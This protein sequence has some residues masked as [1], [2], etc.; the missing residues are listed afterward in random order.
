MGHSEHASGTPAHSA[1]RLAGSASPYLLQHARNPVQWW[2]WG[3]EAF[4]AASQRDVP[5]FLSIGYSTCYWC[6]VMERESFESASTAALLNER[7]V[8][9]KV[10]REERP[11][12]DDIYMN[13]VQLMSGSGGWPMSV[14][15]TP[16]GARSADDPGLEPFYAGTYFPPAP[17]HGRPSFKQV[18][19]GV[20]EAWSSQRE[21]VLEQA[22]RVTAAIR[23]YL[24][25]EFDPVRVDERQIGQAIGQLL[26]MHDSEHGG[27]GGA[28]KFPQPVY[29][30]FL[31]ETLDGI[32]DP[33]A[34]SSARRA[35]RRTLDR[36][37]TGGLFD[38][39]GGGFHRY[40]VDERWVVPHFEK[41]L[42]DNAQLAS[43]YARSFAL[44]GDE[45][46]ARICRRTLD[47]ALREMRDANGGFYSAQDAE[48]DTRE[49]LNYL[50]MPDEVRSAIE[51]TLGMDC[52]ELALRLYALDGEPNFRDPHHPEEPR[53]F[54]L[55]LTDRPDA[56]GEANG[57][58]RD[59]LVERMD[60]INAALLT[61]RASRKQP[62]L[63]D[64]VI[65]AW[66]GM[67]IAGLA[68]GAMALGDHAYLEAARQAAD[69]VLGSMRD[70]RGDLVR[71]WRCGES[72][73]AGV[74]EDYAFVVQGLLALHRAVSS[75]GDADSGYFKA[76]KQ[77][78]DR[79]RVHFADEHG[80]LHDTRN[81][82]SDLVVRARSSYDGAI[83][84]AASTMLHNFIDLFL[85]SRDRGSLEAAIAQ[86]AGLSRE[87][88][89]SPVATINATRAVYRLIALDPEI[90]RALPE[91]LGDADQAATLSGDPRNLDGNDPVVVLASTD[92]VSI[93]RGTPG[94]IRLR[95][96]IAPGYH[97]N[98]HDPGLSDLVGLSVRI[99]NG[100]G[101]SAHASYPPGVPLEAA[102]A[103]DAG[104]ADRPGP[105]VHNAQVELDVEL[106][107][108]DEAWS[109]RPLLLLEYQ[110]CTDRACLMPR[111]VE[112]DVALDP[113]D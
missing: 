102:G 54:V 94:S 60:A 22:S 96:E 41:M 73:A 98:A 24:S 62:S 59:E 86:L 13:A 5:I 90:L 15:L 44:M 17:A 84:S 8:C 85:V 18:I 14:W 112:L 71:V 28:P 53:R 63:D 110:A 111:R 70:G 105:L 27:F 48:V 50:W 78:A 49:G 91:D 77:L 9:I 89:R 1:N 31:I 75:A 74:L 4:D 11:D 93:A 106:R 95:I 113:A 51:P 82:A 40:C 20:G 3:R 72:S 12:I 33:A 81:G 52:V 64:K 6:H 76:A 56:L 16:P 92:R 65:A 109:G 104:G 100:T 79:A 61:A 39:V 19:E 26:G 23:A 37:G 101:V 66:N 21:Q 69:F 80:V 2:P 25:A 108:T 34:R 38:Q 47:Y 7:F 87:I 46:D 68:D 36:M 35:I 43:V 30:E 10:D 88:R 32:D 103:G 42:Y 107:R 58:A 45:F 99:V 83:P 97:I 67:M 29:L 57:I 55:R